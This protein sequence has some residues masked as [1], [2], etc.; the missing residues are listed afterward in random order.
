MLRLCA[1][2]MVEIDL[3]ALCHDLAGDN[4]KLFQ[5]NDCGY[6]SKFRSNL[7]RHKKALHIK[8]KT[9]CQVCFKEFSKQSL[10]AHIQFMHMENNK[11]FPCQTC[12]A[13]LSTRHTLKQHLE[14]HEAH[15]ENRANL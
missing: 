5:C 8:L 10:K 6:S 13:I 15:E 12:G 3:E 4:G 14:T 7:D 1:C 2:N 9:E 11:K